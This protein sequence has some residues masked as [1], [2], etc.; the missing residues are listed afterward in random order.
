MLLQQIDSH[1]TQTRKRYNMVYRIFVLCTAFS[2]SDVCSSIQQKSIIL[3]R[4]II[5]IITIITII[6]IA[7]NDI[8]LYDEAYN[9]IIY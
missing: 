4:E 7:R 3:H 1:Y 9:I 8:I 6:I 2:C 5:I